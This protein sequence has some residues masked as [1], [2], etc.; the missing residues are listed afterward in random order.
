M[1]LLPQNETEQ[2]LINHLADQGVYVEREM[3]LIAY[4]QVEAHSTDIKNPTAILKHS[5]GK[6][7]ECHPAYIVSAEGAHSI[8]RSSSGLKFAGKTLSQ[9]YDL[10]DLH[11]DGA[12]P[13]DKLSI[14]TSNDGFLAVFP[15]SKTRFRLMATD[16][17]ITATRE[18]E[19][20]HLEELQSIYNKVSPIQAR[21]FDIQ[22]SSRFTIN[23][24]H[25]E[26]LKQ[27]KVF[28]GG[29]AAHIHSPA[30]G[31]GMNMGIQDMIN[32][33]WKLALVI[34]HKASSKILDTYEIERLPII[35]NV[36]SKTEVSTE[37]L[38]STSPLVDFA[39]KHIA[40]TV[41][42][43][44]SFQQF[45]TGFLGEVSAHYKESPLSSSEDTNTR[46]QAGNRLPN[47]EVELT[48]LIETPPS[49]K[50]LLP[51]GLNP[52]RFSILIY[53]DHSTELLSKD[54]V[55]MIDQSFS[56]LKENI[57]L[58]KLKPVDKSIWHEA[59]GTD[60]ILIIIRPDGYIG[61]IGSTD[62]LSKAK[63]WMEEWFSG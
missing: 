49:T 37:A 38:N 57:D 51:L 47:I 52:T 13:H 4:S 40:P 58:F 19:D 15:I 60:N 9:H 18:N 5:S 23:S 26:T 6:L 1:L 22:W 63:E 53:E 54:L 8:L 61:F 33:C 29:D 7:E 56:F 20:P 48:Y 55:T 62:Y 39:I 10:A 16:S 11:I 3:E 14:F 27:G 31:Q 41:L 12:I 28:F 25:I 24:R 34:Q 43:L 59:F 45:I 17:E 50:I 35:R 2:I 21:L 44:S 36:V 32:L 46:I 30:G 42:H